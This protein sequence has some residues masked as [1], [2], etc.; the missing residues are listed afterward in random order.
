MK[1]M[2]LILVKRNNL[3]YDI[4]KV[5]EMNRKGKILRY[6]RSL[7]FKTKGLVKGIKQN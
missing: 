4:D 5:F 2:N 1:K 3:K 7:H 6:S